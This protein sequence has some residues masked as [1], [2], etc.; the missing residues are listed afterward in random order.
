MKRHIPFLTLFLFAPAIAQDDFIPRRQDR[1]PGPP[2]PPAAALEA[3]RV[4]V[5]FRVELVAS[6]PDLRNPTAMT[7]DEKGRFWVCESFEYP[8]REPG[9]GRDRVKVLE[10]S[11]GDG[12]VDSVKVFAEGLNIPCAV[13]VGHG[14]GVGQQ[15]ARHPVLPGRRPRRRAGRPARS[16][17]DRVRPRRHARTAQQLHLGAGR[18]ACTA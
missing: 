15:L 17:R 12:A 2:K 18:L 6:E 14:G 8:R 9:P 11:D 10:D 3:M 1:P 7:I 4:P 16:R 5:G 13:A